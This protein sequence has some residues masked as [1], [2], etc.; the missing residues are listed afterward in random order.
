MN[1]R[2]KLGYLGPHGTFSHKAARHYA[3][4]V[5][6]NKPQELKGFPTIPHILSAVQQGTVDV[7]IVPAENSIEGCVNI[8][9]DMLAHEYSLFINQEIIINIHHHLLT[10]AKR[11]TDITTVMSHPQALGQCRRY[12]QQYLPQAKILETSSTAEAVQQLSS[13]HLTYAAIGSWESHLAYKVPVLAANIS[14]YPHNQTRFLV[15]SKKA[16][17]PTCCS[18][19]TSLVLALPDDKPGGLY[20]VL[21][22]FAQANIN[23]SRIESRPAKKEL[24]NYIFFIDCEIDSSTAIFQGLWKQL[25]P[26]TSLLKFLGSYCTLRIPDENISEVR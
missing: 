19:K 2:Q 23:L 25:E 17:T 26:K 4:D 7:G 6:A 12:L 9:F 16:S 24:G 15:V 13:E 8:T 21:G 1:K 10:H 14:D 20:E 18:C 22:E 11:L 3:L 5:K